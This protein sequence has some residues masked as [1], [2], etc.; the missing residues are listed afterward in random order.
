M[1]DLL[2]P[3]CVTQKNESNLSEQ[4]AQVSLVSV[5][6]VSKLQQVLGTY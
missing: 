6:T 5:T 3:S 1:S 2:S 4:K